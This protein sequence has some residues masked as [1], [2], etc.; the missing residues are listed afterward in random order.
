MHAHASTANAEMETVEFRQSQTSDSTTSR[1]L[2]QTEIDLRKKH[3]SLEFRRTPMSHSRRCYHISLRISAARTRSSRALASGPTKTYATKAITAYSL[4]KDKRTQFQMCWGF[5]AV[6][7]R[8]PSLNQVDFNGELVC[9]A[10]GVKSH[11]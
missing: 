2:E 3:Q 1:E 9:I 8:R 4:R 7:V 5:P 6:P 11:F 10:K